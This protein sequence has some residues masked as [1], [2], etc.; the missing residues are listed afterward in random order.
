M[1]GHTTTTRALHDPRVNARDRPQR[2]T[3]GSRVVILIEPDPR[4]HRLPQHIRVIAGNRKQLRNYRCRIRRVLRARHDRPQAD[5]Q[6]RVRGEARHAV[7][8]CVGADI[9]Y[10]VVL[11]SI[12]RR[13]K[14]RG[15]TR[16][17]GLFF[18]QKAR[19]VA[20][21][22]SEVHGRLHPMTPAQLLDF[23]RRHPHATP[24]K[25]SRIR[26]EHGITPAAWLLSGCFHE[27]TETT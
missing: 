27:L 10:R 14:A 9:G 8:V 6:Q 18:T 20:A 19:F 22:M 5:T 1:I 15:I 17:F 24:D 12:R 25:H 21:Q 11:I 7:I 26:H 3:Q 13:R 4:T 16:K 2:I 23:E